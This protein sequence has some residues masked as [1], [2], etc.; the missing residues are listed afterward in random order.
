MAVTFTG[1]M[2]YAM[3]GVLGLMAL[4]FLVG[5]FKSLKAKKIDHHLVLG[6][7][8]DLLYYVFPLLMLSSLTALDS[9]GWIVK[10]GFFVGA[11]GV[12]WKYL[13]DIKSK[14]L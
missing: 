6:V 10:T 8:K 3:W 9:T 13:M 12:I 11:V 5:M 4:D 1:W 7:L 14:I 2:L